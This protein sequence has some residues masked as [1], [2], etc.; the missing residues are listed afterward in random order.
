MKKCHMSFFEWFKMRWTPNNLTWKLNFGN[1]VLKLICA[2]S[3]P[4]E[5]KISL[6]EKPSIDS[7]KLKRDKFSLCN[8]TKVS[9]NLIL[10]PRNKI[11]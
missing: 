9:P 2:Y 1:Q 8:L 11:L 5:E 6:K 10:L 7:E 3:T 4:E